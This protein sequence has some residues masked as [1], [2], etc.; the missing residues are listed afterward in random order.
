[1]EKIE[2]QVT[3]TSASNEETYQIGAL[4]QDPNGGTIEDC[5][6]MSRMGKHQQLRRDFRFVSIVGFVMVLQSAL[7]KHAPGRRIRPYQWWYRR[8]GLG[9]SRRD[10]RC[11]LHDNLDHGDGIYGAD[12]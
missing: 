5:R 6:D 8:C 11:P 4:A 7:G 1:M 3:G 12:G 2:V 9:H 10:N